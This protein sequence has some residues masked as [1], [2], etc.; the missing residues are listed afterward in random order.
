MAT[1]IIA[2]PVAA[3]QNTN[4]ATPAFGKWFIVPFWPETLNLRG[5]I[6]RVAFS[7]SVYSRDII[8][9]VLQKLTTVMVELL[10]SG[11]PVKWDG[12]GTF[13]PNINSRGI[14]DVESVSVDQIQGVKINFIPE[15]SKGEQLTSKA[16]KDL[17]TFSILGKLLTNKTEHTSANGNRYYTYDRILQPLGYVGSEAENTGG[18]N[19][20]TQSGGDNSGGGGTNQGGGTNGDDDDER[21]GAGG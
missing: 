14:N 7:Q 21:P 12:L 15:N 17:C 16:F 5:L 13:T 11:Q 20:G 9:G 10:R 4:D 2:F 6:E 1:Q 8:E 19:G 18:G 3:R